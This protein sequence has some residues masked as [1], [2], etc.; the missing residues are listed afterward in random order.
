MNNGSNTGNEYKYDAFIS[1]RH[2]E[3]DK[4]VA[5][6]IHKYLEEFKL[7]K[8]VQK[9]NKSGKTRIQRVFRDKEELTITNNLEDPIIQALRNSE[10]LIVICSPRLKESIWCRKE[11][12]KFIEFHGRNKILT[13][14][15]EGEPDESF[16]EE[17]RYEEVVTGNGI[18]RREVEPLAADIRANNRNQMCKL[19][20]SE[21]LRIVAP[22]F[23][24]EYDDLR[25]RHRERRIRRIMTGSIVIAVI[26]LII[27]VAGVSTALVIKAQSEQIKEQ[28][29]EI[30]KHNEKLLYNQSVALAEKSLEK[31]ER[32][33]RYEAVSLAVQSLTEYNGIE[34]PYTPQGKY[35]LI[36]SLRLYDSDSTMKAIKQ[37]ETEKTIEGAEVNSSGDKLLAQDAFG[38]IYVWDI[39]TSAL[40]FRTGDNNQIVKAKFL[41]N[42]RIVYLN[43]LGM[44]EVYDLEEGEIIEELDNSDA[45][46]INTDVHGKYIVVHSLDSIYV[47]ETETF[48][49]I[50]QTSMDGN[51]EFSN[52]VAVTDDWLVYMEICYDNDEDI[53]SNTTNTVEIVNLKNEAERLS[54]KAEELIFKSAIYDNGVVYLSL[55]D[56]PAGLDTIISKVMA[57]DVSS[58]KVLWEK[59][60]DNMLLGEV[61]VVE[62]YG[63]KKISMTNYDT[64][65]VLNCDNGEVEYEEK[66][67]AGIVNYTDIVDDTCYVLDNA[68]NYICMDIVNKMSY[69]MNYFFECNLNDI[70][71][72]FSSSFGFLVHSRSDNR[73]VL[74][75]LMNN[76]D[77]EQYYAE[78]GFGDYESDEWIDAEEAAKE[79]GIVDYNQ[80]NNV[81]Y[82]DDMSVAFVTY[83]DG[84]IEI[85]DAKDN[86]LI[87]SIDNMEGLI[88]SHYMGKDKEGNTYINGYEDGYCFDEDYNLIAVIGELAALD[89]EN[90]TIIVGG[91][92]NVYWQYPIYTVDEILEKAKIYL[93]ETAVN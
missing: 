52:H 93:E 72:F 17:L 19:I 78:E 71:G 57:I 44:T 5:E 61:R 51:G 69:G 30:Q 34:L 39:K 73:I 63:E 10:Y 40:L 56:I 87:N 27:A 41:G 58:H 48:T 25:Q 50:V 90:N 31:I 15:I 54:I 83:D 92:E 76:P 28:S 86:K 11:I 62:C 75:N 53:E 23:G 46:D 36:R 67:P 42:D 16:P 3:L 6:K 29:M 60:F 82:S 22:M 80:V 37:F 38:R 43:E 20:K 2:T 65:L 13:V 9:E 4:F 77:K 21:L 14:L 81:I 26:C 74:Y 35:A 47:Y 66:V 7:P 91:R 32:D 89:Y 45:G 33:D 12:E 55:Y 88:M 68:G 59:D 49:N 79:L 24:L 85:Y 8:S 64:L 70:I 1:Y 18:E 84:L